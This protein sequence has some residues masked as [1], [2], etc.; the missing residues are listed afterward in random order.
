VGQ[1]KTPLTRLAAVLL[2]HTVIYPDIPWQL[3]STKYLNLCSLSGVLP[4]LPLHKHL[5]DQVMFSERS[6]PH[7]GAMF[8]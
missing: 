8:V 5:C 7:C 4:P 3:V 6:N 1:A 2:E